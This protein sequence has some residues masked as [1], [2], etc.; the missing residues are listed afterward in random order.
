MCDRP[1]TRTLL[2]YLGS[3][4]LGSKLDYFEFFVDLGRLSGETS[5]YKIVVIF[6]TW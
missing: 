5:N 4:K 3:D 2:E 6:Q 1:F